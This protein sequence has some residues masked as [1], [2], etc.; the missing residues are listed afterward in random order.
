MPNTNR[1]ANVRERPPSFKQTWKDRANTL[2]SAWLLE[3]AGP[4]GIPLTEAVQRVFTSTLR[5]AVKELKPDPKKITPERITQLWGTHRSGHAG[6]PLSPEWRDFL[7]RWLRNGTSIEKVRGV[8]NLTSKNRGR[9]GAFGTDTPRTIY[10]AMDALFG[11]SV[12]PLEEAKKAL[13]EKF[14]TFRAE[15]EGPA[16]PASTV[17]ASWDAVLPEIQR[18]ACSTKGRFVHIRLLGATMNRA[19]SPLTRSVLPALRRQRGQVPVYLDLMQLDP[20]WSGTALLH[21][22]Y[23][24][25]CMGAY[26]KIH[27]GLPK[28][29]EFHS[30]VSVRLRR[31]ASFTG[32]I[33]AA[34]S[35][36]AFVGL[37]GLEESAVMGGRQYVAVSES[38]HGASYL[39]HDRFER[40]WAELDASSNIIIDWTDG[41]PG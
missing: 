34:I 29:T 39:L 9:V 2:R 10:L 25:S 21:R 40:C 17:W 22:G 38:S 32:L 33:G 13:R 20:E 6:R 18:V 26:K 11:T 37:V 35:G 1:N 30:P 23:G 19:W 16:P 41:A 24:K 12:E 36:T 4:P 14:P 7:G 3:V 31:Y 27:N 5:A 28:L 15:A 8:A